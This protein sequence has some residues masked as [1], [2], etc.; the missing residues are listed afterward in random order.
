MDFYL[1]LKKNATK[2]K[3]NKNIIY[4]AIYK[5]RHRKKIDFSFNSLFFILTDESSY[6]KDKNEM[7]EKKK[8]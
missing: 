7:E 4:E 8:I 2:E 5:I 6:K 1:L 3:S